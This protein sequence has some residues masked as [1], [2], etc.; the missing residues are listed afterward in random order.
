VGGGD[1]LPLLVLVGVGVYQLFSGWCG[2]TIRIYPQ[3]NGDTTNTSFRKNF[4]K[5]NGEYGA[6]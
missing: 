4:Q 5:T 3:T 2:E 1:A 6:I